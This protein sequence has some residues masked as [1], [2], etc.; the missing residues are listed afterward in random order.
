MNNKYTHV[1]QCVG[2]GL[3]LNFSSITQFQQVDDKKLKRVQFDHFKC[4][5]VQNLTSPHLITHYFG[6]GCFCCYSFFYYSN[7][8][9]EAAAAAAVVPLTRRRRR[10]ADVCSSL[11]LPFA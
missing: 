5:A 9:E 6:L 2:G 8:E 1:L 4:A 7:T 10:E 3:N 11:L